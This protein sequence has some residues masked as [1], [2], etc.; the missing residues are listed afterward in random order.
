MLVLC[1][2]GAAL[3]GCPSGSASRP[4]TATVVVVPPPRSFHTRMLLPG[5]SLRIPTSWVVTQGSA[6]DAQ[7]VRPCTTRDCPP[8][9]ILTSAKAVERLQAGQLLII[10]PAPGGPGALGS[11]RFAQESGH[12]FQI[13]GY[14]E[15][16]AIFTA[17]TECHVSAATVAFVVS[18]KYPTG[19]R[20]VLADPGVFRR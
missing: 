10:A 17:A 9:W 18:V 2:I 1:V 8:E 12:A 7:F 15:K 14:A 3:A 20:A 11:P 5:V 4:T 6:T 16:W 13:D 19:G